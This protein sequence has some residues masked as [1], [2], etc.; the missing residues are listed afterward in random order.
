LP[1]IHITEDEYVDYTE[2]EETK[3]QESKQS[4]QKLTTA[5]LSGSLTRRESMPAKTREDTGVPSPRFP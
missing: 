5:F 4:S 3:Y 1:A 2:N